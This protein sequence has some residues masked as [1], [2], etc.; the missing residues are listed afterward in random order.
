MALPRSFLFDG[1][2]LRLY[3]HKQVDTLRAPP[4][5]QQTALKIPLPV[6]GRDDTSAAAVSTSFLALDMSSLTAQPL[7]HVARARALLCG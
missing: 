4:L 2:A 7:G 1:S 6:L 3:P 5:L